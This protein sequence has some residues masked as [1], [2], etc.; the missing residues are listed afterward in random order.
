VLFTGRMA[1]QKGPDLLVEAAA[2]VLR[3]RDARFVLIGDGEMRKQCESQAH[4]LGI[5]NSCNFLGYAPD[6]T[7]ID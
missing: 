4:K 5:G 1:Y 6:N 3:K 7:V 2:R